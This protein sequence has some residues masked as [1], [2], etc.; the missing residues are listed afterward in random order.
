[1]AEQKTTMLIFTYL[2]IPFR[3]LLYTI[4][5]PSQCLYCGAHSAVL[6]PAHHILQKQT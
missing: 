2:Q 5:P 4:K 3:K 6:R 1:M